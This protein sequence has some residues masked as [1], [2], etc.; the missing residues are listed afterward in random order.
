MYFLESPHW[1]SIM[2]RRTS[3]IHKNLS[4]LFSLCCD[5]GHI[6]DELVSFILTRTSVYP[7]G[8]NLQVPA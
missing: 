1:I 8:G 6:T 7:A 5:T 3:D 4:F 2:Y